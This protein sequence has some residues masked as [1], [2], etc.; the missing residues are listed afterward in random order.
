VV[1]GAIAGSA[2]PLALTVG[3][4]WQYVLLVGAG[5]WLLVLRRGVVS[6]LLLAGVLGIAATLVGLPV[7]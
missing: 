2:I 7:G 3:H 4:G 6:A 5:L 1:I